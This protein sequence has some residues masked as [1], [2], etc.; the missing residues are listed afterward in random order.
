MS[1]AWTVFVKEWIDALRDRR[2][3]LVVLLSS[4]L[5]GPLVL[6]A[7]SGLMASFESRAEQR[8]VVLAGADQAPTLVNYIARQGFSVKD[9]PADYEARLRRAEL[10]DPVLVIPAGFEV[11][12]RQGDAPRLVVVSDSANKRAEA[13]TGRLQRLVAGFNRERATLALAMRGVS[14]EVLE[15]VRLDERDLASPQTRGTQITGML[16]FFVLMAVLYGALNAALD[17]TAGERE[18]GSLEPLLM[19]PAS[20][21][22][23]VLGKWAAVSAVALL[24]AVLSCFSFI[25]AQWLLRSDSLAALFQFGVGEALAFI[26]VIAPFATAL[27]AVLMAV[28]IRCKSVKEAQASTA[29]VVL[30]VSL[31]PLF[32]LLN[33]GAEEGWHFWVPAL[34]QNTL[35]TRVLKGEAL[36]A[37]PL[38]ASLAMCAVLAVVGVAF[39][40]GVLRR[41][42]VR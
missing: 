6:V 5:M 15:P 29:G 41:A 37:E 39:V 42:A 24:I 1:G 19:N 12:L 13:G 30:G 35:M 7:L 20:P 18:R 23:I 14:A 27:S 2:T 21:L 40:A 38:L 25:P 28:A 26:A 17:T 22:A 9:A 34:A 31:L 8:E 36:G 4:V 3:L 32:G 33:P 11:A 16:P 10:G